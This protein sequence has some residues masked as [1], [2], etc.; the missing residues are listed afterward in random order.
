MPR[1]G[2]ESDLVVHDDVDSA[3]RGVGGQVRQVHGLE[4]HTLAGEGCVTVK[5]D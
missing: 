1:V 2:G 4:H 3:V 5:Q